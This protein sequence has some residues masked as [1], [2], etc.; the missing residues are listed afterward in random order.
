M[1]FCI[2][3]H[4]LLAALYN[5]AHS[6]LYDF[7]WLFVTLLLVVG[8]DTYIYS[9]KLSRLIAQ[10]SRVVCPSC[11]HPHSRPAPYFPTCWWVA[12][13]SPSNEV[14]CL[15]L[16]LGSM[17]QCLPTCWPPYCKPLGCV[18]I[19]FLEREGTYTTPLL[20]QHMYFAN[21]PWTPSCMD[22]SAISSR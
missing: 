10:L 1:T 15:Q 13:K 20:W 2:I 11:P 4:K 22:V 21:T 9:N 3:L 16:C 18:S 5:H 14:V 6:M 8:C 12:S 17:H 7:L 19:M